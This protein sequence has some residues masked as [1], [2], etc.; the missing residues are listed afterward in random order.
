MNGQVK[1]NIVNSQR[2]YLITIFY[3]PILPVGE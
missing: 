1:S 3:L 2:N